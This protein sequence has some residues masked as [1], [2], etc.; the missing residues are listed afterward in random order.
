MLVKREL[1]FRVKKSFALFYCSFERARGEGI[2]NFVNIPV[3]KDILLFL[4][5]VSVIHGS[6]ILQT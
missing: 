2:S 4:I 6:S 5:N 3:I 1:K